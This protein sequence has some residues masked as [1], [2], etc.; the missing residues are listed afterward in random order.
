MELRVFKNNDNDIRFNELNTNNSINFMG[1]DGTP[2][3]KLESN[4]DI[5]VNGKLIENDKDVVDGLREF[6]L[7]QKSL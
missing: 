4:G 6:L 1:K 7:N 5:F 3:L 2:I